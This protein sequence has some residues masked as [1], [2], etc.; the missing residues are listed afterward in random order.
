MTGIDRDYLLKVS[1]AWLVFT[2]EVYLAVGPLV[3]LFLDCLD[4]YA[5]PSWTG[6]AF[7]ELS[8]K[9][10]RMIL[11]CL[12]FSKLVDFHSL[13]SWCRSQRQVYNSI[14]SGRFMCLFKNTSFSSE[15]SRD[16]WYRRSALWLQNQIHCTRLLRCSWTFPLLCQHG[17]LHTPEHSQQAIHGAWGQHWED[18][19]GSNLSAE[20]K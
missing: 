15:R 9:S 7:R 4:T 12:I 1:R 19:N 10:F 11:R 18:P 20:S 14:G 16:A 2:F 8:R 5:F 3:W 13:L 6:G 17:R